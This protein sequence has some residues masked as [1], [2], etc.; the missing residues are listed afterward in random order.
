MKGILDDKRYKLNYPDLHDIT[1]SIDS[2]YTLSDLLHTLA[3]HI[4]PGRPG[5]KQLRTG[6]PRPLAANPAGWPLSS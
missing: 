1:T 2:F 3:S 4:D 5:F 6:W